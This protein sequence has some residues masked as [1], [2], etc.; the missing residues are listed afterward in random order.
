MLAKAI[1][2]K[3]KILAFLTDAKSACRV[4]SLCNASAY[5]PVGIVNPRGLEP[6]GLKPTAFT[7]AR[8]PFSTRQEN[9]KISFCS[10]HRHL[11]ASP[12]T[13]PAAVP[14]LHE[15]FSAPTSRARQRPFGTREGLCRRANQGIRLGRMMVWIKWQYSP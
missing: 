10:I 4:V 8:H 15:F 9:S 3:R 11:A 1:L 5:L 2:K 13:A 12:K 7:Y 14:L 6:Q